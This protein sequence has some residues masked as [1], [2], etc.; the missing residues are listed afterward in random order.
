MRWVWAL[1]LA[2][3]LGGVVVASLDYLYGLDEILRHR[4]GTSLFIDRYRPGL[5]LWMDVLTAKYLV[6]LGLFGG[7]SA[8]S[9]WGLLR[10]R[11]KKESGQDGAGTA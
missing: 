11:A 2:A 6:K 10:P 9:A 5:L 3:G 7:L 4:N 1:F 8:A